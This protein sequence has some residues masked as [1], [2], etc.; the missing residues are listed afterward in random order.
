MHIL[1]SYWVDVDRN[2]SGAFLA[3]LALVWQEIGL[4]LNLEHSGMFSPNI[5]I[6]M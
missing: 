2:G 6:I 5:I 4:E 1:K 3:H